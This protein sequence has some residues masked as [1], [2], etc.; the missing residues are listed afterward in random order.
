MVKKYAKKKL[1]CTDHRRL[2]EDELE[3]FMDDIQANMGGMLGKPKYDGMK[4]H[5]LKKFGFRMMG[6][7]T[8]YDTARKYFQRVRK[9][10]LK[11][12]I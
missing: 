2:A 11:G 7:G 9:D 12:S 4:E 6:S 10:Y 8:D 5:F 1:V 3:G